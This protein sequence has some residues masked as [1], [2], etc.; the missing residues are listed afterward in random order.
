MPAMISS[1]TATD[2]RKIGDDQSRVV[3]PNASTK[4]MLAA[5]IIDPAR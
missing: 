3:L 4:R 5:R 1:M 2:A